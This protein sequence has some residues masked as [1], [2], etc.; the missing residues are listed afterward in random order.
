MVRTARAVRPADDDGV[1]QI[2]FYD[3]GIGSYSGKLHRSWAGM[4]RA[5]GRRRR[6]LAELPPELEG[7]HPSVRQRYEGM[8]SY[9]PLNLTACID[10]RGGWDGPE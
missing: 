6:P 5:K 7:I 3:W 9:R 8:P 10:K 2:V 1:P 4:Y